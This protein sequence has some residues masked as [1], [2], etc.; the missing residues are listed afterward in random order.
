MEMSSRCL[1]TYNKNIKKLFG[2]RKYCDTYGRMSD[3]TTL[4]EDDGQFRDWHLRVSLEGEQVKVLCCPN[5]VMCCRF[6]GLDHSR[7]EC[8][9]KCSSPVFKNVGNMLLVMILLY[10]LQR[11]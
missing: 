8:C 1:K 11:W 2:L 4:A 6:D 9:D 5:D 10:R 7:Q 3:S